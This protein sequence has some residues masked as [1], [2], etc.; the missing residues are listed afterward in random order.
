ME[1]QNPGKIFTGLSQTEV[2]KKFITEG[3]N[4]IPSGMKNKFLFLILNILKEPM[5]LLLI[6]C[7]IIYFILG[8]IEDALMLVSFI[9]V[10]IGITI[11]QERKTEKALDALKNL[12]SPRALVIR[13]GTQVNIPGRE[14]VTEDII[15]LKEGNR[16]PADAI[17][18]SCSNL[19]I[20][21]SMLT[22]ESIPVR[23]QEIEEGSNPVEMRPGGDD[24]PY[25]YSG[26]MIIQGHGLAKVISTGGSTE[27]GKIGKALKSIKDEPTILQKETGRII[28]NLLI[29]GG[30]LCA[31]IVIVYGLTRVTI[32]NGVPRPDWLNGFLAGLSLSMAMLPEEFSVVLL[33]FLTLGAWRI[34]KRQVLARKMSA[35]ETL[36][37]ASVL[38]VDKTGT[39]TMNK[40][41]LKK[42][43]TEDEYLDFDMN[44]TADISEK[45]HNLL[46]YGILASQRDPFDPIESAIKSTGE[47]FLENSEHIH[48]SWKL[49]KEYPL[50]KKITALSHIW[51]SPDQNHFVIAAKGAP[52]SIIELCHMRER[53]KESL[54]QIVTDLA[55]EGYR[56]LGVAKASFDKAGLPDSQHEFD[57]EFIGFLGFT[58]PVRENVPET[59]RECYSAGI[60]VIMITGDYPGTAQ[61]IAREIGLKNPGNYIIGSELDR[62]SPDELKEKIKTTNIFARVVPEQKL[63]IVNA[64]KANGEIV[65]MT[66]DGVNDAP[67]LKSAH[68]GIAMGSRGT[69]VARESAALVLLDD[70][71]SSIVS[72]VRLGRRIYNNLKKA[73][74]YIFSIHIP[75]ALMSLVPV[76]FKLPLVLLPAHIAFLELIIDPACSTVFE[77]QPEGEN[78]MKNKPRNIKEPMFNRPTMLI[79]VVNGLSLFA[80]MIVVYL[81][82]LKIRGFGEDVAR[83]TA[84]TTLVFGNLALIVTNA[85]RS[86]NMIRIFKDKNKALYVVLTIAIIFLGAALY[87]PAL[88]NIFH[89]SVLGPTDLLICL[90]LGIGT[91]LWFELLKFF[92]RRNKKA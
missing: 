73:M 32:V 89:F 47:K 6:V 27:M 55:D 37:S 8:S 77:A 76:L 36:G 20:D 14:V 92:N 64:L 10:V 39:L 51:E 12:S 28:K 40:M 54:L 7:G 4:E 67:A 85:S 23:K 83:T 44:N 1:N 72:A 79:S 46:E 41:S 78:I 3:Y 56:V 24:L 2:Q 71:F 50:S 61:N 22:G 81:V 13:D 57:F 60:R 68:I 65:A 26:T 29:I 45:F 31:V 69:D 35:I 25:V 19:L 91:A 70:D 33:I 62:M 59:V 38:C 43:Y 21:E 82:T 48:K 84:F 52:E 53:E 42:I 5:L 63:L 18:F 87:I 30:I 9:A 34:S 88:R 90:A 75:I 11:Y 17:I 74:S 86:K 49:V 80:V 66:G 58:D 15:V 16:V